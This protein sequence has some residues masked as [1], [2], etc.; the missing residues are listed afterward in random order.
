MASNPTFGHKLMLSIGGLLVFLVLSEIIL[1]VVYFQKWTDHPFALVEL[2]HQIT[3]SVG[4]RKAERR[5][6]EMREDMGLPDDVDLYDAPFLPE[7]DALLRELESRYEGYFSRLAKAARKM[8]V[9]LVVMFVPYEEYDTPA[10]KVASD[11][12]RAF[13]ADLAAQHQVDFLDMA[14]IFFKYPSQVTTLY[15]LDS[16]LSRFGHRL[17]ALELDRF[18]R[19]R[20][21]D[22]RSSFTTRDK[23]RRFGDHD[24]D[25]NG[26]DEGDIP[27]RLITNAQGLRMTHDLEFPKTRQRVLV[28]GDSVTYGT[29]VENEETYTGLLNHLQSVREYVNAGVSGYSIPDELEMFEERTHHAEPD[30]IVLQVS[31]NDISGLFYMLRN[32]CSRSGE[33]SA[34]TATE[35]DFI[36]RMQRRAMRGPE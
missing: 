29:F 21:A 28:L 36:H 30:V 8:D 19:E 20:Y 35:L 22:A 12:L 16:H 25:G 7:G 6:R 34:P 2:Y 10:S 26:I 4:E 31:V 23:P 14:E 18:I 11:A 13:L 17:V 3:D 5:V 9:P 27:H 32:A 24:P 33:Q 1:S 15:P